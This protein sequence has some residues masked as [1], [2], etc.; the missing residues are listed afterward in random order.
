M[1]L[2]ILFATPELEGLVQVGGLAAVSAAL[3]RALRQQADTRIVIPGYRSVLKK[4][5]ALDIIGSCKPFADL[6]GCSVAR[7]RTADGTTLYVV[8]SPELYERDGGPYIDEQ[9]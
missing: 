5:G 3:P 4:L 8:L 7:A 9:G 1:A 6:P 2:R